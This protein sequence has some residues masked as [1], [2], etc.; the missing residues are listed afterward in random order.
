M[1]PAPGMAAYLAEAVGTFVL[2]FTVGCNLTAGVS[3]WGPMSVAFVL[4]AVM[5]ALAGVSGAH[6]NPAVSVAVGLSEKMEWKDVGIYCGIQVMAG[7]FAGIMY[8]L[9]TGS[10][11]SLAP[12]YAYVWWQAA[13]AE[14]IYTS[15][16]C[17]VFLCT[18]VSKA[19]GDGQNHFYG[20]AIGF[21]I[22]AGGYSVGHIS[23]ACL[24]PAVAV[25]L[26]LPSFKSAWCLAYAVFELTGCGLAALL[27]RLVRPGDFQSGG[28]S[29]SDKKKD[30]GDSAAAGAEAAEES[31]AD[32][33][34]APPEEKPPLSA[35]LLSETLGTFLVALT[36]GL[37]AVGGS[38]A[39][40][41]AVGAAVL[42][43]VYAL[44]SVSGGHFNPAVTLAVLCCGREKIEPAVAAAYMGVQCLGAFLGA[45]LYAFMENG[46]TVPL[47]PVTGSTHQSAGMVEILYTFLLCF[48]YLS[49]ATVG[50]KPNDFFGIAIAACVVAGGYAAGPMSGGILN[51]AV[52]LGVSLVHAFFRGGG[53]W[54]F[55]SYLVFQAMGAILAAAVF[56]SAHPDEFSEAKDAEV[57]KE[58][59]AEKQPLVV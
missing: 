55:L 32:D 22:L 49:V 37:C 9:T 19:H 51:P 38:A 27:F 11:F 2:V 20:L 8:G 5:Y 18:L 52:S 48:V 41:L 39:A 7:V 1:A 36:A 10:G 14:V 26:S 50:D 35:M 34:Q 45:L 21:V 54:S 4:M 3:G 46:H 30:D 57:K 12:A 44:M 13:L 6:L 16:L 59:D 58:A 28:G 40:P 43:M 23:G 56:Y 31:K 29:D 53:L 25:G 47:G 15:M 42:C 24:N 17:L 33:G